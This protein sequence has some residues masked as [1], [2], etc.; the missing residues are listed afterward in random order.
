VFIGVAGPIEAGFADSLSK[1]SRN[2]TGFT[3]FAPEWGGEIDP[4]FERDQ[5]SMTQ[6]TAPFDLDIGVGRYVDCLT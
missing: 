4:A 3:V 1:P 6:V 5:P 2:L